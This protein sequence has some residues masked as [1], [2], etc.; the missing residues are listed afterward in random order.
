MAE[1][2]AESELVTVELRDS[3]Y[4]DSY[5]KLMLIMTG[6]FIAIGILGATSFYLYMS[7]PKPIAFAVYK[8]WRVQADVPLDKPYLDQPVLLQWVSD[9][10]RKV[11]TFD[12]IRYNDQL[13]DT[14]Q[15][16]T[17]DG[18]KVFLNQLNIYA[19]Y[20]DVTTKKM[21]VNSAPDGAPFIINQGVLTGRYAWW[22]QAPIVINYAGPNHPVNKTLTLQVLVV[23]VPTLNNLMGVGID[24]VIV[25]QG[26]T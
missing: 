22:I 10:L 3:F 16:F 5:G 6:M 26:G 13:Q 7:E 24:N 17:S 25:A 8:D 2:V 23:R 15:Y 21:F 14:T 11:F 19:N 4:R 1:D 12:F 9:T 20:N 18:W